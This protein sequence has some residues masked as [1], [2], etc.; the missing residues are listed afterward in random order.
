MPLD[1]SGQNLRGH[2]FKNQDLRGADFSGADIRSADF[3]GA[4]LTG[5]NFSHAKAGLQ[6]RWAI[7]LVIV[8]LLLS[9]LSGSILGLAGYTGAQGL[10]GF[11]TSNRIGSWSVITAFVTFC[12]LTIRYGIQAG[13][14]VVAAVGAV[15]GVLSVIDFA[16]L[17]VIATAAS[18]AIGSVAA[19]SAG[20]VVIAIAGAFTL[21][22]GIIGAVAGV[23]AGI[24]IA[25]GA[26]VF[27]I[28]F[29]FAGAVVLLSFYITPFPLKD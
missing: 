20:A 7:F 9:G 29:A 6:W 18:I 11:Q 5:A 25:G 22:G 8:S 15:T 2:S 3:S 28:A 12:L 4:N 10:S 26:K 14:G 24:L 17:M 27:T 21:P 23:I 16:P 19:A 1:Y 13:L